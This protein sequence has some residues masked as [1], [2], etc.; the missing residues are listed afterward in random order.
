MRA[1]PGWAIGIGIAATTDRVLLSAREGTGAL[2][3]PRRATSRPRVFHGDGPT[4]QRAIEVGGAGGGVLLADE[5]DTPIGHWGSSGLEQTCD[6][7]RNQ[8][9]VAARVPTFLL[10]ET[11]SSARR[12]R[13]RGGH[14]GPRERR[15]DLDAQFRRGSLQH[16]DWVKRLFG[17]SRRPEPL[18]GQR[19]NLVPDLAIGGWQRPWNLKAAP[20]CPAHRPPRYVPESPPARPGRLRLHPQDPAAPYSHTSA[21]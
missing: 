16:V 3:R 9:I 6:A 4:L 5:A 1:S 7:G 17:L 2:P 20:P 8:A 10:D 11:K 19:L 13:H 14:Q 12:D 21:P 18:G 15:A